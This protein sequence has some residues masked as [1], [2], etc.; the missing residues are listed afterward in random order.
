M[1]ERRAYLLLLLVILFWAG[2]F[3]LG[4]LALAE[5]GPLT[6]TGARALVA[7]PLLLAMARLTAPLERPLVRRDYIAFTVLGVMG[8]V[9]NTTVWYWGLSHTTAL[10]AGILSAASPIFVAVGA[11]LLLGDPLGPRN[12]LGIAVSVLSVLV[13]VSKGSVEVLASFAFNRGDVLIL[14]SQVAWV[15]YSLYSRAAASTLPPVWIMAGAHAVAAVF[16]VP[17]AAAVEH[18]WR[19][20]TTA[21]VGWAVV[22]YG[23]IPVTLGHIWFFAAIRRIGPGRAAIFLNLM[24]FVVIA[25]SWLIVGEPVYAYHLVGAVL[26]IAGVYLATR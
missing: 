7:A 17:L 3:P 1:T 24:P 26:V 10:N 23:A 6:L 18:P 9:A 21:P 22:L 14:L 20:W 12:W 2:N 8:L 13:T 11:A 19:M 15:T 25:L 16:L 5:L 4:K